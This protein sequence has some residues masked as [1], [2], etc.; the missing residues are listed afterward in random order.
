MAAKRKNRQGVRS[1]D[2][3]D[4]GFKSPGNKRNVDMGKTL[5]NGNLGMMTGLSD[6][7]PGSGQEKTQVVM[8]FIQGGVNTIVNSHAASP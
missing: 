3:R 1:N 5:A 2:A 4:V 8:N 6:R 7:L